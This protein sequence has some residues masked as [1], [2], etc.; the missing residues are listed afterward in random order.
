MVV[1]GEDASVKGRNLA[2]RNGMT[3]SQLLQQSF[4]KY[5]ESAKQKSKV[6]V[7]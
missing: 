6:I 5:Q 7:D 3:Y 2:E 4:E 1:A